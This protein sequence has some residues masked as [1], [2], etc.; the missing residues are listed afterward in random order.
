LIAEEIIPGGT[1]DLLRSRRSEI[2]VV[3]VMVR[4]NASE[5]GNE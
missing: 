2:V 5:V 4:P 3:F 1:G